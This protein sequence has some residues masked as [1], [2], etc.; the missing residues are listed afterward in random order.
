MFFVC[1]KGGYKRGLAKKL[2]NL[3]ITSVDFVD[4]GANQRADINLFKRKEP[5]GKPQESMFKRFVNWLK[6][7]GMD[8]AQIDAEIQKAAESFNEQLM[9]RNIEQIDNE[10]WDVTSALRASLLSIAT[11][12]ELDAGQKTAAMTESVSQFS[13]AV[14]EYIPKW[15]AGQA[16]IAKNAEDTGTVERMEADY[17]RL[18]EMIGKLKPAE[19][20]NDDNV[21]NEEGSNA[22]KGELEEMLKID[23]SKMTPEE[24]T[25][26]EEI[27]KKYAV[28]EPEE[29]PE[30]DPVSQ[31][32]TV[33]KSKEE[34][35]AA[36]E[37]PVESEI[38]KALKAQI[39][40]A[41]KSIDAMKDAALT[42]EVTEVAKKY[43]PLGKKVEEL[44]PVLKQMKGAGEE[45][46][47]SY[48]T[49][50][51]QQLELQK[52][53]GIFT[54]FGK[55]T[56]GDASGDPEKMWIAK[57]K[58][59]QKTKPDLTLQQAMDE[60]ALNDDELRAQIDQ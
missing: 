12:V 54:E 46:Y 21:G 3:K 15:C 4:E 28:D 5:E 10:M 23:K 29:N 45:L 34:A 36:Q 48:I 2:K 8:E 9:Q 40:E 20:V 26:Y 33:D 22:K 17:Q 11:D 52:S 30:T 57:A 47:T 13:V 25:A 38:V 53:S 16:A 49:A 14:Q 44:V 6:G 58:E 43:V 27:V 31:E 35:P 59:L 19:P 41:R 1:Q 56:T 24:V 50:L 55:S 60:V 39:E 51:D 32:T 7:E 37:E 18:G 42:K